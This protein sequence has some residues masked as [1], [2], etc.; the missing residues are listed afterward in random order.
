MAAGTT[1]PDLVIAGAARS[2]TSYLASVLS[3]HPRIDAGVIKEP[4]YFSREMRRGPEWY[5]SLYRPREPGLLRLDAS[6]SYTFP[7]F[8]TALQ[9]LAQAAPDAFVVYAVREPIAR[10]LSHFQLHRLYFKNEAAET[11]GAALRSNRVYLGTSDYAHWLNTLANHFPTSRFLL[12]PF[13]AIIGQTAGVGNLICRLVGLEELP[14]D[15]S[16]A[17]THRNEVV[18]FRHD[19]IK[20][21]R[22]WVKKRR[23]YPRLRRAVGT[24][25]LRAL[26]GR[27]TRE[28]AQQTLEEALQSCDAEQIEQLDALYASAR[29]AVEQAL[30]EQDS[31]LTLQWR[32]SWAGTVPERHPLLAASSSRQG[33]G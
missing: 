27:L 11:F 13:S 14:D 7:H 10:A 19:A 18:E 20:K 9:A 2:G 24:D 32:E 33:R 26:R 21:A 28:A 6:M 1:G 17:Q 23:A 30:T 12:A 29:L 4:N 5:D 3:A 31:R 25:R 22:R 15:T 16:F 8:P